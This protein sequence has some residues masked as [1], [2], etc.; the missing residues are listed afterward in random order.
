MWRRNKQTKYIGETESTLKDRISEHI[1]YISFFLNTTQVTGF[2][3]NLPGHNLSDI[4]AGGLFRKTKYNYTKNIKYK[5]N[6]EI[7]KYRKHKK[8]IIETTEN[9]YC[10]K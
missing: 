2:H 5:T 8:K 6:T 1:S 9:S 7:Q 3:F 10:L 4:K